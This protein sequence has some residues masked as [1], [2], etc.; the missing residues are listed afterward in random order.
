V[1]SRVTKIEQKKERNGNGDN[2]GETEK[3]IGRKSE[4]QRRNIQ[5]VLSPEAKMALLRRAV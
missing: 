2:R 3:D 5:G 4:E 1:V